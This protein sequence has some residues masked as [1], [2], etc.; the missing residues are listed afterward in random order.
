MV[1][2]IPANRANGKIS[3]TGLSKM[4]KIALFNLKGGVGKTTLT[5]NLGA[6]LSSFGK[7]VLL[8][9]LDPQQN[10]TQNL[11]INPMRTEGIEDFLSGKLTFDEVVKTYRGKFDFIPAGKSL[12]TLEINLSAE[13]VSDQKSGN[14]F[15]RRFSRLNL[16]YDYL[17]ID[18]PPSTGL[19]TTNALAFVRKVYVPV[20]CH[21]F[22]LH[23]SKKTVSF[24]YRVKA[25]HN[26]ELVIS[27]VI[28]VMYDRRNKLSDSIISR[29]ETSFREK[30]TETKIG[31]NIALA[32]APGFGKTIF[33]YKPNSRGAR[34]IRNLA[35]ELLEREHREQVSADS[36][37][38]SD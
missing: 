23:G 6:A 13:Y 34:D 19:L 16:D 22:A 1:S 36:L 38:S 32:E 35:L 24:V 14:A 33:D 25:F 4:E 2:N 15:R 17:M 27:A 5:V 7:K 31:V 8:I 3:F 18:C 20:Q 28:P 26:P 21:Q 29:L 37:K 30:L 12:K 11:G 10:L 9:D